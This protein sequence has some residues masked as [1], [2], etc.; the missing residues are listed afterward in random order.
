M[1]RRARNTKM[2]EL[3]KSSPE[4][5]KVFQSAQ[6]SPAAPIAPQPVAKL[7]GAPAS[8]P[9]SRSLTLGT[10]SNSGL[11]LKLTIYAK[12]RSSCHD[13]RSQIVRSREGGMVSRNC[14][15]CGK[16]GYIRPDDFPEILCPKCKIPFKVDKADGTNYFFV[17]NICGGQTKVAEIVPEWSERFRYSGL[18]AF[19][20]GILPEV[21]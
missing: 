1:S 9:H 20:D 10:L 7:T 6:G 12:R 3:E 15:D 8:T 4:R 11:P 16:P 17:C 19:G 13:A 21:R 2:S 18:A 5:Q 14:E